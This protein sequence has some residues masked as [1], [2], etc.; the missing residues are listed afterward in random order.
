MAPAR[1]TLIK[2]PEVTA[3]FWVT[4]LLTT[5]MGES[6]S[7]FLVHQIDPVVAVGLGCVGLAGALALQ[8][9]ARR[10]IPWIYWLAVLM[11]A[12][13]GT[14]AA[15]VLHIKFGVPYSVS[16][17]LF[18]V[19]LAVV[20]YAWYRVEGTLSIHSVDT[21]RRELFYWAAVMA[22]FAMGTALGDFT[23][24]TLHLGFLASAVVF[25]VLMAVPA[26]G[27][28][29]F[30]WDEVF[31]FWFAYVMTRPLG[32]SVADWLGKPHDVGGLALGDGVVTLLFA[33]AIVVCVR[34]MTVEWRR[35]ALD[36]APEP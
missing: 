31:S 16:T 2:V 9:V 4:K 13:T 32:A 25:A 7:D 19:V 29:R 22:T 35:S 1:R 36:Y 21:M 11:V 15:D 6:T 3:I 23:A 8:L 27:F 18:A 5:A 28:W 24:F 26:V 17:P 14:M 34:V 20:F 12:I 10:Y 30:G 33:M